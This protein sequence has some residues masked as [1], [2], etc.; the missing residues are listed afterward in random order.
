MRY[1]ADTHVLL[2][3]TVS[4]AKLSER[5]RAL[6]LDTDNEVY[7]SAICVWEV[8]L[9]RSLQR[10]DFDV[11]PGQFLSALLAAGFMELPVLSRHAV[12]LMELPWHHRDPF[13]RMLVAQAMSEPLTVLTNDAMIA[14][15][16]VQVEMV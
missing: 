16:P 4:Q 13:D 3:A 15:Y 11:D 6:L 2:W 7:F 1:L 10:P 12:R 5:A 9:K 8:A 14:Q